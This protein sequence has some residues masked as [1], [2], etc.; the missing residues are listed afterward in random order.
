[1]KFKTLRHYIIEIFLSIFLSA[2]FSEQPD[3][4]SMSILTYTPS[5][6]DDGKYLICKAENTFI[7]KSIIEDKYRLVVQCKYLN[8]TIIKAFNTKQIPIVA[9]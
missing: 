9:F 7:E 8:I 6:E 5:I 2:Q 3:N 4:Q 1:M